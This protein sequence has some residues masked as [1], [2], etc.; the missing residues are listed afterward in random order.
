MSFL[1]KF[2]EGYCQY[3]GTLLE[4]SGIPSAS[5]CQL[6]CQLYNGDS[7]CNYFVYNEVE[8]NCQFLSSK[9]RT[10]DLIRGTPTPSLEK[11]PEEPSTE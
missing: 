5:G 2:T 8:T 11:C 9:E 3:E 1:Q 4:N 10:C 6:A 7:T